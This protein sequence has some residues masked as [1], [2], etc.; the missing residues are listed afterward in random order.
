V[1]LALAGLAALEV[2]EP[3]AVAELALAPAQIWARLPVRRGRRRRFIDHRPS[4]T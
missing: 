1:R 3:G 2:A 4:R